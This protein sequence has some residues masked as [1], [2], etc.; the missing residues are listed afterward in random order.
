MAQRRR[1]G[2]ISLKVN[3]ELEDAKGNFTY[4]LGTPM[5]EGIVGADRVHGYKETPQIPFIEGE[6]TD[7]PDLDLR[8]LQEVKDAT[9]TLELAV[10]KVVVLEEANFA[11][12]GSGQT[13][14]GN[15]AVRFEGVRAEEITG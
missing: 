10:G 5:R 7:R 11:G 2:I 13:E 15:I 3:G 14:E 8:A 4:N 9:I 6:I 12:E 1:G